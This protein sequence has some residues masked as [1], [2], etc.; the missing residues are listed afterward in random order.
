MTSNWAESFNN[1]TKDVRGFSITVVVAFLSSKVQKWFAS[2]KEKAD[3]WTKPLSPEMEEDLALHF[4]KSR[5]LN[6]DSCGRYTLQVHPGGTVQ[7]NGIVD[8]QEQTC[9]CGLFQCMKFLCPHACVASQERND[10]ELPDD[11]KNMTVRVPIEKQLVGQPKNQKVG[12]IKNNRTAC[13]CD[14][15]EYYVLLLN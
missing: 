1:T 6:I 2:R 3:K 11:I 12:R 14:V 10:R 9:T 8:L 15:L 7:T 5:Y 4:E 13:N